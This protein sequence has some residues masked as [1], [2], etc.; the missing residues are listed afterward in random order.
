[1]PALVILPGLDGTLKLRDDFVSAL[2][3]DFES[4]VVSYPADRPTGY[5][6][7]ASLARSA[8]PQ[9]RPY[10]VLGESFSG[11][12]AISIAASRPRGLIGLILSCSFARNPRPL[13]RAAWPL[14]AP[15]PLKLAPM[16]LLS[17]LLLGRFGTKPLRSAL[18]EAIRAMPNSVL[19]ARVSAVLSVDVTAELSKLRVPILYLRTSEDRLV[20]RS[21]SESFARAVPHA[22]IIEIEGPHLL[23]QTAPS[24]AAAAIRDFVTSAASRPTP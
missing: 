18:D 7:L 8:L 3:T 6:E 12:I 5:S 22:Q 16:R 10:A 17:P 14:L 15:V 19:R 1:M 20:P 23:L 21:C 2:G 24:A 9:D 4:I 11:P 13:L